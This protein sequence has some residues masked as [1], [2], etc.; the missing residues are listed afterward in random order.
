MNRYSD[1]NS[2]VSFCC[3]LLLPYP[4]YLPPLS[5]LYTG[6]QISFDAFPVGWD[7]TFCLNLIDLS[8]F[9]AV[10]FFGDKTH[11][12]SIATLWYRAWLTCDLHQALVN[13]T[14]DLHFVFPS[15]HRVVMIMR[16]LRMHVQLATEWL[17]QKT[18]GDNLKN[19]SNRLLLLQ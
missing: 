10:H 3:F 19:C 8:Q 2:S 5:L 12:V 1:F 14:C 9:K 18:H 13:R 11:P 15:P 4:R 7:K 16:Y 17:T 6:G